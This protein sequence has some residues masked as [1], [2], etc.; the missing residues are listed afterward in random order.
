MIKENIF[1]MVSGP[2]ACGKSTLVNG[3]SGKMP[4]HIYPPS[5]SFI[6]LSKKRNISIDRAFHDIK[7]EDAENHFCNVCK[8]YK[9]VVGDQHLAIQHYKD[10]VIASGNPTMIFPEEPYVSAID[11]DLFDKLTENQIHTLLIYLKASP[12]ILYERAYS[13]YAE[14]GTYIRNQ[15]ID[16]VRKEV[17]AEEYYFNELINKVNID[18]CVIDTDYKESN[19]V[20]ENAIQRTLRFRG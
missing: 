6:E 1:I 13:R 9:T 8:K 2:A 10:S 19:E 15:T 3:L 18:N 11:Y 14:H 5:R 7:R 17:K 20:L 16:E 12:E 4:V